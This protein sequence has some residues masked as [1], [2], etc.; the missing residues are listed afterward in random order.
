MKRI[1]KFVVLFALSVAAGSL[2]GQV[3]QNFGLPLP[4]DPVLAQD[5]KM[6]DLLLTTVSGLPSGSETVASSATPTFS[7]AKLQSYMV[8]TAT[9]TSFTLPPGADGQIKL[10]IWCQ[11]G[12]GNFGVTPPSNV[13]GFVSTTVGPT[14]SK[15]SSTLLS[16]STQQAAWETAG[17]VNQ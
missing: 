12:T 3:T 15:C 9:V 10:L 14:A 6:L 5:M 13:H 11:N 16:Y 2:F 17:A 4:A 8:I 7:I 1:L